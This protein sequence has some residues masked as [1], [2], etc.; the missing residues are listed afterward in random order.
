MRRSLA[1]N[2]NL[3]HFMQRVT[4]CEASWRTGRK[5]EGG[6]EGRADERLSKGMEGE[7][8]TQEEG[9]AGNWMKIRE[10]EELRYTRKESDEYMGNGGIKVW[11]V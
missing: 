7:R 2:Y 9:D 4:T 3:F 10:M 6:L 8:V 5:G 11:K 1:T